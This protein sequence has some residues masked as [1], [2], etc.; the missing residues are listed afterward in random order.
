[1]LRS[2]L[3]PA[4]PPPALTRTVAGRQVELVVDDDQLRRVV[5]PVALH[6]GAHRRC[7]CRSCTSVGNASSDLRRPPMR[8]PRRPGAV[9]VAG[10]QVARGA[11]SRPRAP[12]RLLADVVP[13]AGV[14]LARVAQSDD[15]RVD[16]RAR[17]RQRRRTDQSADGGLAAGAVAL[18]G[19]GASPPRPRRPPA[20]V[21]P[22]R[23]AG[24]HG[25]GTVTTGISGSPMAVTPAGI[26]TSARRMTSSGCMSV[27]SMTNS[28]GMLFGVVV[29][30]MRVDRRVDQAAL[31]D[32]GL[33]LALEAQRHGDG[34]LLVHVDL[35]EVDV[36]D[37]APD[38]VALHL[39]DDRRVAAAV[40]LRGRARCSSRPGR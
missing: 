22:R 40:D 10:F 24:P 28:L 31:G 23:S 6:Q 2:P 26:G 4:S 39:L 12:T 13:G 35:E 3:L 34:D 32:H 17:R 19:V 30:S 37:G 38:R 27:M 7:R 15:E 18:G 11:V 29:T 8:A 25:S 1:M 20:G 16:R 36:A 5:E 9:A 33:G 21:G 14:L